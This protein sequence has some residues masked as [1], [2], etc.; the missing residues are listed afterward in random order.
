MKKIAILGSTGSIGVQTLSIVDEHS[1]LLCPVA[2]AA[3]S[4]VKLMEEQARK[5]RPSAVALYDEGSALDLKGRI[6]DTPV[7]VLSGMEGL[8]EIAAYRDVQLT[9]AAMVGMA[10]I[11]PALAAVEAGKDLALANKESLV[12]AG[13]LI[14][15][16]VKKAGVRL[17]PVDS[18]H[19]AIFQCLKGEEHSQIDKL[20]ITASGG[21]FRGRKKE[22][23]KSIKIED[24]LKHPN[25]SMGPKVTIDSSTLANK[26][27]EVMEAH[28]LFDIPYERIEAVVHP[29]S[30]VHSMVQFVDGSVKAQLG[31]PDMRLPIQYALFYPDRLSLS[32]KR[33]DFPALKSLSFEE[34]DLEAFPALSL[35]FRAAMTGGS[36]P[37]VF[38]AVNEEAVKLFLNGKIAYM[39]IPECI[40]RAMTAHTVISDPSLDEIFAVE[41]ETRALFQV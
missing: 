37:T 17:L 31:I 10:G 27:L 34:P 5:Y 15:G 2:L 23:L 19:S 41:K 28:W 8:L 22:E 7:K 11:R 38:N 12:A 26:G 13:H 20:I 36:L 6:S 29:E 32:G 4:N 25:W 18:E 33:L 14:T 24:A 39:Q 9:V 1:D 16:A 3:N 35:A 21:P 40:E 30:I